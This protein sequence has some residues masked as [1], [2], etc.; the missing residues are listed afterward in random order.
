MTHQPRWKPLCRGLVLVA[1]GASVAV[2]QE[3]AQDDKKLAQQWFDERQT[4]LGEYDFQRELDKPTTLTLQPRSLLNWTNPERSSAYGGL[5]LWVDAGR[6]QMLACAFELDG[7]LKHEFQS[8]SSE[9][10]AAQR[11]GTPV[12]R[13]APG[14]EFKPLPDAPQ[15]AA[16]RPLRLTQMRRMAERFRVIMGSRNETRL[17]PQPVFRS[18]M[19]QADDIGV[20]VFVQGTDPECTLLLEATADGEWRYALARQTKWGLKVE[21]DGKQVW[22]VPP[23]GRLAPESPFIV[24]AQK[25]TPSRE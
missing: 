19:T 13:F 10:I 3:A 23:F 17:L 22:D 2:A 4:E 20:F 6:P 21:L 11:L 24:I 12:H 8:L 14:V 25:R 15:R 16:S 7:V 5:Y 1:W 9:P 18:P